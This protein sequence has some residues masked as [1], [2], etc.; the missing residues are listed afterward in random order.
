MISGKAYFLQ[1]YTISAR[2]ETMKTK[3]PDS[4]IILT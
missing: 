4:I 1:L 2:E 3:S